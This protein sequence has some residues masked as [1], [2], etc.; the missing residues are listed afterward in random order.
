VPL[1]TLPSLALFQETVNAAGQ[2]SFGIVVLDAA[3]GAFS[4]SSFD[5]DI[6][7]TKLETMFRQLQPKEL[8]HEKGNL[9]VN[10]LRTL[11][12]VLPSSCVWSSLRSSEFLAPEQTLERLGEYFAAPATDGED[13]KMSG[14]LPGVLE[15]F[16][17]NELVLRALGGLLSSV[18]LPANFA[19]PL[20][21]ISE[22]TRRLSILRPA[23]EQLP[24]AAQPRQGPAQ[25]AEL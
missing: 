19:I 2:S 5:D 7:K 10:T 22:L 13:S 12:S 6:V 15:G 3:T 8:I 1:L 25:S 18:S 24:A 16:K 17:D 14:P 11:R 20:L 21:V 23:L 4:L 9:E